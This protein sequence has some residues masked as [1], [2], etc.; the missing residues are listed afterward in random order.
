MAGVDI[1]SFPIA[2]DVDGSEYFPLVQG[3]GPGAVT[4]RATI[5]QARAASTLPTGPSGY[6]LIGNGLAQPTFQGFTQEGDGALTRTWQDKAA[7]SVNAR[8]FGAKFDAKMASDG[9]ISATSATF[10]S[11]SIGFASTDVGKTIAIAGAGAAGALLVTSI[12]TYVSATQVTLD[13][14]ASTTVS[15]QWFAYGT[16][17]SDSIQDAVNSL[18]VTGGVVNCP[19]GASIANNVVIALGP[20]QIIGQG[21]HEFTAPQGNLPVLGG[22]TFIHTSLTENAFLF[23]N[24]SSFTSGVAGS[25]LANC[26]FF[27]VH[28]A[29]TSGWAPY[30]YPDCVAV[31]NIVGTFRL[32]NVFGAPVNKLFAYKQN[33]RL[34]ISNV[35]GQAFTYGIYLTIMGDISRY[36]NIHFWPFWSVDSN[37]TDYTIANADAFLVQGA[38]G[39]QFDRVFAI[40]MRSGVHVI[41]SAHTS[42]E[43]WMGQVDFDTVKYGLWIDNPTTSTVF[44]ID[45]F[46]TW[47]NY[48]AG[49]HAVYINSPGAKSSLVSIGTLFTNQSPEDVVR[50]ENGTSQARVHIDD[51]LSNLN[52]TGP[53]NVPTIYVPPVRVSA[54][55]GE[56]P[57]VIT[58]SSAIRDNPTNPVGLFTRG[59]I[60]E[61]GGTSTASDVVTITFTNQSLPSSPV[62]VTY[63][64][65]SGDTTTQI[66]TGIVAA[67]NANTT[68]VGTNSAGFSAGNTVYS[69]SQGAGNSG[70]AGVAGSVVYI[71]WPETFSN[72]VVGTSVSGSATETVTVGGRPAVVQGG[73]CNGYDDFLST[74]TT[75]SSLA[76]VSAGANNLL[77]NPTDLSQAAWTKTNT[78]IA[79][80]FNDSW[81]GT[82][83]CK[84]AETNANGVHTVRQNLSTVTNN[85]TVVYAAILEPVE[86][87]NCYLSVST[88][89]NSGAPG[90]YFSLTGEG[91]YSV[92]TLS[93]NNYGIK[94][95]KGGAY[96]CWVAVNVGS[97]GT[98]PIA[99]VQLT[100]PGRVNSYTGTTGSG[101]IVHGQQ[102]TITTNVNGSAPPPF[103]L[104]GI[105]DSAGKLPAW[106]MPLGQGTTNS[107]TTGTGTTLTAA[108]MTGAGLGD[109]V[110]IR[111]GPGSNFTD[112]TDSAANLISALFGAVS[113]ASEAV[114][115]S[116][117]YLTVI[118][119]T[120]LTQTLTAG[121]G[122]TLA[123]NLTTSNIVVGPK[124]QSLLRLIVT[125]ASAVTIYG[126]SIQG[127][128][129]A[130]LTKADD[131]N[132]TLTLGGT[133]T[134]ALL[135]PTSITAGWTGQLAVARGG[136]GAATVPAACKALQTWYVIAASA[137]PISVTGTL[138]NTLLT[139]VL[140]PANTMGANGM[141]RI[142]HRWSYTN[143]ANAKL[144]AVRFNGSAVVG[145]TSFFATSQTTTATGRY[146]TVIENNNATNSQSGPAANFS[147]FGQSASAAITSARDTTQNQYLVFDA[148]LAD[149]TETITLT[150]YIVE[151]LA[152]S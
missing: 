147:G 73:R 125:S 39:L 40:S 103:S 4:K 106:S 144:F 130:A 64:V 59:T 5:T 148:T 11:T 6:A 31:L 132:V 37:V 88:R 133:P 114:G 34:F 65:Q 108:Q 137:V 101:L 140:I 109:A 91:S 44:F 47:N 84:I 24:V 69:G 77:S 136:T 71:T 146:Q 28:K 13:V 76:E 81:G 10:T 66:A 86:R 8:D 51:F 110:I 112:T 117:A 82:R 70:A 115:G 38:S 135:V 122:V 50:I 85:Q 27:E 121:S 118:N 150:S 143:S 49:S 60:L 58:L 45:R 142:T 102:A 48:I 151:V 33:G 95:L 129:G 120:A 35:S 52:N 131:T 15:S 96:L 32:Q 126:S 134:T 18:G 56:A 67:I 139:S 99:T 14:A 119:T 63:T 113:G 141:L 30:A 46:V 127:L 61:V 1:L 75:N 42:Q 111:S 78:T 21:F 62:S 41:A 124:S 98:T 105:P 2:I 145:G 152:Q 128:A 43:I 72:V 107:V 22:T 55:N 94:L 19:A 20:V 9:A 3:L 12:A 83:A 36:E 57:N 90:A 92:G 80:G 104:S 7:D 26:N 89:S 23:G 123:G 149:V 100:L 93:A 74:G 79:T 68:L 87:N 53:T 116:V 29:P 138:S 25:A 97:G 17:D 54:S 16:D